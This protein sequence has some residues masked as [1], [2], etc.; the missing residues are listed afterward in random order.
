MRFRPFMTALALAL[1]APAAAAT[2][3]QLF[4]AQRFSEA[5]PV[6]RRE[7]T[8]SSLLLAGRAT[9]AVAAFQAP[10]KKQALALIDQA[11]R[12]YAAAAALAPGRADI[13]LQ[14]AIAV[15]YRAKID[16]SPKGAKAARDAILS[17]REKHPRY[18]LAWSALGGW[19]GESV[20]TLGRM[21]AGAVLGAKR[22]DATVCF[23]RAIALEPQSPVHP[24]LWA[25]AAIKIPSE[26]ARVRPLL[27]AAARLKPRDGFE[28]LVRTHGDAVLAKLRTGD[29][30]GAAE[31]AERV[32]P[33]AGVK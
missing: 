15:G 31:L 3:V 21:M 29:A 10:S 1:G 19:H 22:A 9:L 17:I 23:E 12:D 18:A 24:V 28:L 8:A 16:R 26:R 20:A 4:D 25:L 30:D 2:A 33:F 6:G 13:A 5:A 7:G 11:E 27:E 14:R 32:T